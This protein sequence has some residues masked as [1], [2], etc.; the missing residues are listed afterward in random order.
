[1][2][3]AEKLGK[4]SVLLLVEGDSA[5]SMIAK[6]RDYTKFGLLALRG[7]L[8]NLMNNTEANY[9]KNEEV[10]LIQYAMGIDLDH[11][12]PRKL[13]Y[14][15]VGICVDADDDG[16]HIA[17]LVIAALQIL[18][19]QFIQENRLCWLRA[20]LFVEIRG[21]EKKY[22]YD[23][24][25]RAAADIKGELLRMK[26]LGSLSPEEMRDAMFSDKQRLEPIEWTVDGAMMLQDLM[27][28][29]AKKRK[30]FIFNNIDFSKYG[31]V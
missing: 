2:K 7:K 25:E 10:K 26:G 9:L 4:D 6:S 3:D 1:M 15:K 22:Y 31:E 8:I 20:P 12:N 27:G 21:K 13:R 16:N 5:A 19:P 11:Y 17:L 29:D 18:C 14:G 24:E 23:E 30:D 28:T